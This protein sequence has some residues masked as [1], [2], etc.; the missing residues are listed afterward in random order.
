MAFCVRESILLILYILLRS[1][2]SNA[3]AVLGVYMEVCS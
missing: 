3:V 2:C 1:V